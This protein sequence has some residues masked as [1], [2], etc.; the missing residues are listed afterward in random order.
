MAVETE[1]KLR[2]NQGPERARALLQQYGFRPSSP[3]QL[4]TDQTFDLPTGELRARDRLLRLRSTAGNWTV[5]YKGP[6]VGGVHKTREEI[7]TGVSDGQAFAHILE[8]LGYQP[9]F[10]YEKFRTTFESSGQEGIVMLDETPIGDFLELEGPE[11]WID[12]TSS[13]LGFGPADYVTS[14][15]AGLY[16]EY[17]RTH[18]TDFGTVPRNMKFHLP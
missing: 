6:P 13:L 18:G 8:A 7:E 17:V 3:R 11:S 14:S 12:Q 2:L 16:E 9:A 1:V 10:A 4:E 15:Y 5:T